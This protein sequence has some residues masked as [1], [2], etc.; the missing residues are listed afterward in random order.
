MFICTSIYIVPHHPY[1]CMLIISVS[2]LYLYIVSDHPYNAKIIC[3][4]CSAH[5]LYV[6][7]LYSI[8]YQI[9]PTMQNW[10]ISC[11]YEH[12]TRPS[13]LC[14]NYQFRVH[15]CILYQTIPTRVKL[16]G[17]CSYILNRAIPTRHAVQTPSVCDAWPPFQPSM[18]LVATSWFSGFWRIFFLQYLLEN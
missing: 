9:I 10:S 6:C 15:I 1:Y 17:S 8:L 12:H 16:S 13:L 7:T 2:F 11:L 4:S 18:V 5:I 14:R 3:F